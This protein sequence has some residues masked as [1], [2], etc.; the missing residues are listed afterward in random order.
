MGAG[1]ILAAVRQ[2]DRE[3]DEVIRIEEDAR[4]GIE[5][6]DRVKDALV[7]SPSFQHYRITRFPQLLPNI[8]LHYF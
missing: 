8:S 5:R 4:L 1:E 3:D 2:D 7:C 6:S